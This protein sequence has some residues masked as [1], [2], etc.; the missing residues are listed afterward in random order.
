MLNSIK[1]RIQNYVCE[2][3]DNCALTYVLKAKE[4]SDKKLSILQHKEEGIDCLNKL[5]S[6]DNQAAYINISNNS[7]DI[8][9]IKISYDG[10]QIKDVDLI[11][12]FGIT[13][14]ERQNNRQIVNTEIRFDSNGI[15]R[16]YIVD[17]LCFGS[18]GYG[19]VMMSVLK[20]Y[21]KTI[22]VAYI[23]GRLSTVDTEDSNDPE[24]NDRLH[25]FYKKHG[26]SFIKAEGCEYIKYRKGMSFPSN[27]KVILK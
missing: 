16:C 1:L 18:H 26:F 10:I 8:I 3:H 5:I 2:S 15:L 14:F 17:F 9:F 20:E 7:N 12:Y 25:H 11:G 19:S 27:C 22:P 6:A 13:P 24:H 21:L 4:E 23:S